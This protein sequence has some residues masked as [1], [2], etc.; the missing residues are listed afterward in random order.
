M[1]ETLQVMKKKAKPGKGAG[2]VL[3]K[4]EAVPSL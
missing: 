2:K 4:T 3:T 1:L